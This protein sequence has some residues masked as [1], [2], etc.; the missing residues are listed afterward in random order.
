[1]LLLDQRVFVVL[2]DHLEVYHLILDETGQVHHLLVLSPR[3]HVLELRQQLSGG[4]VVLMQAVILLSELADL[5]L[6]RCISWRL[7]LSEGINDLLPFDAT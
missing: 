7:E 5:Q 4:R 2:S 3:E 1:M 6:I